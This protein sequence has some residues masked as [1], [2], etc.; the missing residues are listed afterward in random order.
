MK[1][2]GYRILPILLALGACQPAPPVAAPAAQAS[3]I[4]PVAAQPAVSPDGVIDN[5][6]LRRLASQALQANRLY[7]PAGDNAVEFYLAARVRRPDD[8]AIRAALTE[9]QPYLLIATEQALERR[10]GAEAARLFE[11]LRRLDPQAP[12]LPRLQAGL[13]ALP[14]TPEAAQASADTQARRPPQDVSPQGGRSQGPAPTSVPVASAPAQ[15]PRPTASETPNA[16]MASPPP[17][18]TLP[19]PETARVTTAIPVVA[20]PVPVRAAAASP[21][22]RLLQ[23]AQPRYP[24]P[25]LRNRVEGEVELAFVIRPDGS[26]GDVRLTA[27]RPQGVFDAAAVAVAARWRFEATGRAQAWRRTVRFRLPPQ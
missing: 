26:V 10:D 1:S 2:R 20:P 5:S 7:A 27:A 23:D 25:A 19:P 13:T 12:A 15:V 17:A 16:A 3:A 14:A 21:S 18:P 22:P 24:L 9:I 8:A 4:V 6:E 11:L